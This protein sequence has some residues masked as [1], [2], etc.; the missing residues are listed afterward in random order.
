MKKYLVLLCV[1][2]LLAC[3]SLEMP[4]PGNVIPSVT[5]SAT[6]TEIAVPTPASRCTVNT[7]TLNLRQ[8]AGTHCATE[9]W[10]HEG[11]ALTILDRQEP[12]LKVETQ[13]RDIGWV[14]SKYCTGE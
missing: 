12:W 7:S 2:L 8:C 6:E 11:E 9:M 4:V 14:H 1:P 13:S 3:F 10:L 5:A